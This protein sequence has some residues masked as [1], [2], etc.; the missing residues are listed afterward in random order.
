[1]QNLSAQA[2]QT[3]VLMN[4]CYSNYAQRNA[5]DLRDLLGLNQD[6]DEDERF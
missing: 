3:H 5:I 4:N 6:H 1:L 2:G